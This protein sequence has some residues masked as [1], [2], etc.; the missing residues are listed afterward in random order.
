MNSP[1]RPC[2]HS[3]VVP[4]FRQLPSSRNCVNN[5]GILRSHFGTKS[6]I[7][8]NFPFRSLRPFCISII[9]S[10][11]RLS[12]PKQS[13]GGASSNCHA[14]SLNNNHGYHISGQS[15]GGQ[16]LCFA[17]SPNFHHWPDSDPTSAP[18]WA[19]LL[20]LI[21]FLALA[22]NSLAI[23]AP[24]IRFVSV[25]SRFNTHRIASECKSLS[26]APVTSDAIAASK[27]KALLSTECPTCHHQKPPRSRTR[28]CLLELARPPKLH[29]WIH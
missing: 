27:T 16:N 5:N 15:F 24:C 18:N 23:A 22:K 21:I 9:S 14:C 1:V 26:L 12:L 2:L 19:I 25:A 4:S 28:V 10:I 11:Y 13:L 6:T 8:P 17:V 7:L 29:L 3:H 20:F